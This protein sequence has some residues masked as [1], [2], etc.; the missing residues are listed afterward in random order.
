MTDILD[1]AARRTPL[2]IID[3]GPLASRPRPASRGAAEEP[4]PEAPPLA[5]ASALA[6]IPERAP[7]TAAEPAQWR[8]PRRWV[9]AALASLL[10]VLVMAGTYWYVTGVHVSHDPYVNVGASGIATGV[11][12]IVRDADVACASLSCVRSPR[13]RLSPRAI[14]G[15][16]ESRQ[17]DLHLAALPFSPRG[18]SA[19]RDDNR[20]FPPF[21]VAP[22]MLISLQQGGGY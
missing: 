14:A 8:A 6:P 21:G 22:H 4:V 15:R 18:M 5:I 2:P 20:R 7:H 19:D 9:R 13:S 10:A 16:P 3:E 1:M 12:G 17:A 11:S